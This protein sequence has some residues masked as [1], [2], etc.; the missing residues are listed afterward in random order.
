MTNTNRIINS[1]TKDAQ[2]LTDSDFGGA[3][4]VL[5]I[6]KKKQLEKSYYKKK[7]KTG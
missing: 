5:K 4:C 2:K 1:N 7:Q 3:Y 6:A